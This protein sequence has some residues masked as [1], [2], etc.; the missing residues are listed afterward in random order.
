[1]WHCYELSW[2]LPSGEVRYTTGV[3]IIPAAS[4]HTVESKSLKLYL[5]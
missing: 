4:A 5:N 3:L 2:L 1:V